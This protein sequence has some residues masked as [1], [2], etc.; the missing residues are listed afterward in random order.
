MLDV[1]RK[2]DPAERGRLRIG[3]DWN[4]ITIIALSQS[5][6][7]KA[8]AEFV[9]NSAGRNLDC[10]L[11]TQSGRFRTLENCGISPTDLRILAPTTSSSRGGR[12]VAL[13]SNSE[14]RDVINYLHVI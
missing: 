4:A 2:R 8:V 3:D 14:T 7:L 1:K 6:P 9:E 11:S 13:T 5:N 12:R 10:P